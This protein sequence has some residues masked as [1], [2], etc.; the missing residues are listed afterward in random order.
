MTVLTG[1]HH[2]LLSGIFS[3]QEVMRSCVDKKMVSG[4]YP[5]Y[6]YLGSDRNQDESCPL[7]QALSP[8][9]D[10]HR[11][12]MVH[13]LRQ[14]R[15]TAETRSKV[16]PDFLN[17]IA[18][19][20]PNNTHLTQLILDPNSV[21]LPMTIRI[22]PDHPAL[23]HVP[24]VRRTICHAIHKDRTRQLSKLKKRQQQYQ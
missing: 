22:S 5:C 9:S 12:D 13:L 23:P 11:E 20:F 14:C 18:M 24:T 1:R 10:V 6:S 7:C 8:E 15:S 16:T 3:T 19:H 4:D 21:N 17:T 2:P